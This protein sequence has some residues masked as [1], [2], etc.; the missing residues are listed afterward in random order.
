MSE[1][2]IGL[3]K[4]LETAI[5]RLVGGPLD[6]RM[7]KRLSE[8]L[9]RLHGSFVAE[10][11]PEAGGRYLSEPLT[12]AAYLAYFFPASAAQVRRAW[13]E[14]EPPASES[15]RV[16]DLGSGPGPAAF[17]TAEWL[18]AHGKCVDV[19]LCE[20]SE[21]ALEAARAMWP[22]KW[23]SITTKRWRAGEALP[24]GPFDLVVASHFINELDA[25]RPD[26]ISRRAALISGVAER[27]APEG[28]LLLVEPALRRTGRELLELRAELLSNG[29]S[30]LAPC[31]S[32]MACPSLERTRD[33]CHADRPWTAPALVERVSEAAGIKR[34]SL[35]YSYL[36]LARTPQVEADASLFRIV[37]EPMPERGK[38]RL[39]GCGSAGRHAL[40]RLDKERTSENETFD[41]LERGDIV[42]LGETRATGDGLRIARETD[43]NRIVAA[44]Q[45]DAE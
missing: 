11:G 10:S 7:T 39:F 2:A 5:V 19:T 17:A 30:V 33:W 43:V 12:L 9:Q 15:L 24:P 35:K 36:L 13:E 23:G 29:W 3:E 16:L 32:S 31:L 18:V 1:R 4:M 21:A 42:R 37:S 45:K 38:L 20:S 14:I 44:S 8:R 6:A 41:L 28:R 27:F 25:E 22:A 26:R 34:D 40:V